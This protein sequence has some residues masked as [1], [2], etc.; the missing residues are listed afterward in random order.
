MKLSILL[1]FTAVANAA[2]ASLPASSERKLYVARQGS[3]LKL[4]GKRWTM[5]GANVYWL[6]L[7]ENVVPPKGQ[8]YYAPFMASYPTKGRITEAMNILN[9][10][11]ARTIRS[12][13]LGVSVGNPLSLMPALGKWNE[14]AF[15]TIDWAVYQAREHGIRIF[16]PLIDNYASPPYWSRLRFWS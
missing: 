15:D 6:G 11:G 9:T 7:D 5:S 3:N 4:G 14:E 12:Q 16:A 2:T 10:M 13:T 1:A 8:P